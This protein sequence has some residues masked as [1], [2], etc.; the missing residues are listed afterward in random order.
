MKIS[1][2]AHHVPGILAI[3]I[4]AGCSGQSQLGSSGAFQRSVTYSALNPPLVGRL[5]TLIQALQR[6]YNPDQRQSWMAPDAKKKNLLYVSD[7]SANDV[8]VYSYRTTKLKGTL[9]G[10]NAPGGLCVDQAGDVFIA[11]TSANDIVEYAHGGTSPIATLSDPGEYPVDCSVDP[12]SGNLAVTNLFS[13]SGPGS[14][15]IY[16]N[17]SGTP[18]NYADPDISEML[19]CGYDDHGNLF[20]DGLTNGNVFALA[21]LP[22][23]SSTFTNIT[24]NQSINYP[25]GVQWDGKYVALGDQDANVI[26]RLQITPSGAKVV[27]TVQLNDIPHPAQFWIEGRRDRSKVIVPDSESGG[28]VGFWRYPAGGTATKT[29]TGFRAPVGSTVSKR[30]T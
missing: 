12:T 8:Y 26:Y 23:G 6:P 2:L 11:N 4:L 22:N 1:S 14:V 7:A 17:A 19:F 18:T 25:G 27:G 15:S 20:L 13:N 28:Y 5:S 3:A 29:I 30:R 9:T 10:F 16:P 24:L 21:E